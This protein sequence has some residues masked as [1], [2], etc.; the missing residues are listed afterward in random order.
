MRILVRD[1]HTRNYLAEDGSWVS[2][3][4]EA[5]I[6]PTILSAGE[7]GRKGEDYAVVLNYEEPCCELAINPAFC[8]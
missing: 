2:Q 7:E 3:A 1:E 6:F 5:R 8:I 4:S